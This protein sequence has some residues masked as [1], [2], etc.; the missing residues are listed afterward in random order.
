MAELPEWQVHDAA[1]Y[2]TY[3]VEAADHLSLGVSLYIPLDPNHRNMG[4]FRIAILGGD[5]EE[6]CVPAIDVYHTLPQE[7]VDAMLHFAFASVKTLLPGNSTS[8]PWQDTTTHQEICIY[9]LNTRVYGTIE[10]FPTILRISST[11]L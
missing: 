4:E 2:H 11:H 9:V 5:D 6:V 1:V 8:C 10:T 7:V 3:E